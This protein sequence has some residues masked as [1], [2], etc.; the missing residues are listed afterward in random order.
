MP[1]YLL[2]FL[3]PIVKNENVGTHLSVCVCTIFKEYKHIGM[4]YVYTCV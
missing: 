1:T 2:H 4:Y 3:W